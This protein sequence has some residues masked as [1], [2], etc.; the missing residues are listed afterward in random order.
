MVAKYTFEKAVA[1]HTGNPRKSKGLHNYNWAR[2][3]NLLHKTPARSIHGY[4]IFSGIFDD[5]TR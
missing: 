4:N 1:A 3:T 2:L 5:T